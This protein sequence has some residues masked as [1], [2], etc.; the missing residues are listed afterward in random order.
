MLYYDYI[1]EQNFFQ[2]KKALFGHYFHKK[3]RGSGCMENIR[4]T[5]EQHQFVQIRK[6]KAVQMSVWGGLRYA[7]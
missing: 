2:I 7:D 4:L 5:A 1:I 6:E 3:E